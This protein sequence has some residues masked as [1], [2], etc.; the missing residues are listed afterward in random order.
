MTLNETRMGHLIHT[1]MYSQVAVCSTD[2]PAYREDGGRSKSAET[3]THV[4]F[5]ITHQV[6]KKWRK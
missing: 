2:I 1:Y 4:P 6:L 5:M 3:H